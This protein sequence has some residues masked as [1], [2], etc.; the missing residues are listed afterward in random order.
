MGGD[1]HVYRQAA[2]TT[3]TGQVALKSGHRLCEAVIWC[4][5]THRGDLTAQSTASTLELP[6]LAFE[7][8]ITRY[9]QLKQIANIHC[10]LFVNMVNASPRSDLFDSVCCY[11]EFSARSSAQQLA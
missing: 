2:Q 4:N 11:E 10:A 8:L 3:G 9:P 6:Y 5:W 7:D 1:A